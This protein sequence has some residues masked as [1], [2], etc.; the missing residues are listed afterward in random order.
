ML[1]FFQQK[2]AIGKKYAKCIRIIGF[3]DVVHRPG[4][5]DST[6]RKLDLFPSSGEGGGRHS[7]VSLRKS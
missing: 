4:L 1:S 6:F 5:E 7:V 2:I 3:V